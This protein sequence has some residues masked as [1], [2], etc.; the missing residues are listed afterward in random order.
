MKQMKRAEIVNELCAAIEQDRRSTFKLAQAAGV[1]YMTLYGWLSGRTANPNIA[2][3]DK[4]ARALGLQVAFL[5]GQYRLKPFTT[6]ASAASAAK[7]ARM[8]L[9]RLQ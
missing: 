6:P 5:D 4:V 2:T 7:R 3:L 8:A 1:N 9:W